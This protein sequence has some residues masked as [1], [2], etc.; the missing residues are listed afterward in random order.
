MATT[1]RRAHLR[2]WSGL[3]PTL[4][5]P[6]LVR[7]RTAP[8]PEKWVSLFNGK[9]LDGWTPKFS[10]HEFGVNYNDTFR[11]E[12]GVLK[13]SYDRYETFG[14]K[15]GHIFWKQK[16]SAYRLRIEYRFV[17]PQVKDGPAWGR[18]NSG[19]MIHCQAPETMRKD[20][21][22]PVSIEVQ[23]LGADGDE[24]RPTGNLCT[25][26][27][28]VVMNGKLHTE[29]CT[30]STSKSYPGEQWVTAEVEVH[31]AGVVR[32][33]VNGEKVIEYSEPQL[34]EADGDGKALIKGSNKLIREGYISLQ[35]ESH[36]LEFRKVEILSL[37][38]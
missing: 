11:V 35:A 28:N 2:L 23:F 18:R 5:M 9:N 24:V 30:N 21:D 4:A 15:F 3:V 13:V 17:G 6:S 10:G 27:T 33:F 20:Q 32:H 29:H 31:G 12:N 36:P 38:K 37:D 1:T 7:A 16:Y 34:D 8:E 22:F 14:N 19:V 26:G 25:P